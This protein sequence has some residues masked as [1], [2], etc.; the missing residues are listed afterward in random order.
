MIEPQLYTA[1]HTRQQKMPL[2]LKYLCHTFGSM[3]VILENDDLAS[4]IF[5]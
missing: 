3:H 4:K 1:A 5:S 2:S